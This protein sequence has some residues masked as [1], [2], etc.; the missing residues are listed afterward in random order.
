MSESSTICVEVVLALADE[1]LRVELSVNAGIQAREV[2]MLAANSGMD[3][4][5]A[6]V[7]AQTAALGVYSRRVSDD[8]IVAEGDRLEVYRPLAQNPMDLRRRRAKQS[9]Q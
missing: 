2:V 6:G 4:E 3:F 8:Y 9:A 1:A 5:R 7:C